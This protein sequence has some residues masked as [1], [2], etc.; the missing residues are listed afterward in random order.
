MSDGRRVVVRSPTRTCR[1]RPSSRSP[2]RWCSTSTST[3]SA[4]RR[5]RAPPRDAQARARTAYDLYVRASALDEDPATFDEAEALYREAIELDPQLA[6][7]YTNLGNIRFRRGDDRRAETLYMTALAIDDRQPEAHYN[8]GY[9]MLERGDASARPITS[10]RRSRATRASP[11]RTSTSRWRTSSSASD[12][13]RASTGSATSSSSP[14]HLGRHRPR[15]PFLIASGR[16]G[17][18]ALCG[19]RGARGVRRLGPGSLRLRHRRRS[20]RRG[21][22]QHGQRRQLE[23]RDRRTT[24]RRATGRAETRR[25]AASSTRVR[26]A[27]RPLASLQI[28]SG[29]FHSCARV[30]D[31]TGALLGSQQRRPARHRRARGGSPTTPRPST[32]SSRA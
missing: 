25:T 9:V 17:F 32:R 12:R 4:R 28:A 20:Q 3:A 6:I 2:G 30:D 5:A 7:A 31:G 18:F 8:L 15:A 16:C 23:R 22:R 14:G 21:E 1:R 29:G 26:S 19:A 11:T 10:R 27:C 13:A 24:S